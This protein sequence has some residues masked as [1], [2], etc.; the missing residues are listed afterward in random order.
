MNDFVQSNV[1][2]VYRNWV[3][4]GCV[5]CGL[6]SKRAR[7]GIL[8]LPAPISLKFPWRRV[9]SLFATTTLNTACEFFT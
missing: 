5:N 7:R 8:Y 4:G 1:F 3:N 6:K 9:L 2:T